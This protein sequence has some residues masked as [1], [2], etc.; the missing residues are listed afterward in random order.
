MTG[1]S[2]IVP[3]TVGKP[4]DIASGQG[5]SAKEQT[6]SGQAGTACASAVQNWAQEWVGGRYVIG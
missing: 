6:R 1:S 4:C 3:E 5:F 2:G